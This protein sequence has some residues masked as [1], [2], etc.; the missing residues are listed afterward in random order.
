M[1][2]TYNEEREAAFAEFCGQ[3]LSLAE[4]MQQSNQRRDDYMRR[5]VMARTAE[6]LGAAQMRVFKADQAQT[7]YPLEIT[8]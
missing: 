3:L 5:F 6:V 7:L 4:T 1:N 2:D 8:E